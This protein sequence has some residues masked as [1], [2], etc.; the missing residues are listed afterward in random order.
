MFGKR[1]P[2][3]KDFFDQFFVLNNVFLVLSVILFI[4]YFI[5]SLFDF[6]SSIRALMCY[7]S[8]V[9]MATVLKII[10]K[11]LRNELRLRAYDYPIMCVVAIINLFAWFTY[12]TN[13]ILSILTVIGMAFS[14]RAWAKNKGQEVQ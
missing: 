4:I 2:L 8:W 1:K 10:L 11:R 5:L 12:P 9:L 6:K 7:G 13:I 3:T 14:Y